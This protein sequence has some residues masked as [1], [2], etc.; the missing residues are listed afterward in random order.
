MNS[1][2]HV[3][4]LLCFATVTMLCAEQ[5]ICR[6]ISTSELLVTEHDTAIPLLTICVYVASVYCSAKGDAC[7]AAAHVCV[8]LRQLQQE[9][10]HFSRTVYN[11]KG[12]LLRLQSAKTDVMQLTHFPTH[13]TRTFWSCTILLWLSRSRLV[14][15]TNGVHTLCEKRKFRTT[16]M[17]KHLESRLCKCMQKHD[18]MTRCSATA[19]VWFC[20]YARCGRATWSHPGM[21]GGNVCLTKKQ[22]VDTI[23]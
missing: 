23:A 5:Y 17:A 12:L 11:T 18:Q 16:C 13:C 7:F 15:N 14:H 10:P 9:A 2:G 22:K 8:L 3:R 19:S 6:N 21:E 1:A 4:Q 20:L